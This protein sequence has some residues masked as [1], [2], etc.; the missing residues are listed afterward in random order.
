MRASKIGNTRDIKGGE[1]MEFD[2]LK[3]FAK[4]IMI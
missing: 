3:Y 1:Q 2:F 4:V